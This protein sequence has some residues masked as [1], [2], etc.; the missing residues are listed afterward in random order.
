[1]TSAI[2]TGWRKNLVGWHACGGRRLA[3]TLAQPL[4]LGDDALNDAEPP[5]GEQ[6]GEIVA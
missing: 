4:R 1:M 3:D 6:L 5:P 2:D